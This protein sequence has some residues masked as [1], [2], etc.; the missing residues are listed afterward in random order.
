LFSTLSEISFQNKNVAFEELRFQV[1]TSKM[2]SS[3]KHWWLTPVILATRRLR[4]GG[5]RFEVILNKFMNLHLSVIKAGYG[6]TY[7]SY[8]GKLKIEGSQSRPAWAKSETL[9][10]K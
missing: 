6:G 3:A 1:F 7:L 4:S 10:P 8:T 9:S 2:E 5:S